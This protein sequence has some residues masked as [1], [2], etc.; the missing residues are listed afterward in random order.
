VSAP[1]TR[2]TVAYDGSR[3]LGWQ[4]QAHGLTV[5]GILEE[6]LAHVALD[7]G[8]VVVHGA[9]RTDTGVHARG[10]VAHVRHALRVP[11]DRLPY[12]C[13]AWLPSDVVVLDAA[14]VSDDF[15]ARYSATGK[16]YGYTIRLHRFPH[17]LDR[18]YVWRIDPVLDV[19]AM[20][21]AAQLLVGRH[22]FTSFTT[23]AHEGPADR[24]RDLRRLDVVQLGEY[25]ELLF[26]GSG[27]LRNMVRAIVGTLVQVGHGK[28][29]PADMTRIL[30]ANDRREAGPTAPA[31]GLCLLAVTYDDSSAA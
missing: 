4:R 29:A 24:V 10:Q 12:A 30:D 17:P 26:E 21:A 16:T 20:Q 19:A 27:F 28:R 22:D 3:F 8:P 31:S 25:L 15:H 14:R 7:G 13:N 5:Q 2:L 23:H 9:G 18:Q 6:A 11:V 1:T